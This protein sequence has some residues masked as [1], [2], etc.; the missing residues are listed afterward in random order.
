MNGKS[1]INIKNYEKGH[2]FAILN[3]ILTY[4]KDY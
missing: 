3:D 2:Q 4:F 1:Q